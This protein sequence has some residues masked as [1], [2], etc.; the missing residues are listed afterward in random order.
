MP[1]AGAIR[2][3]IDVIEQARFVPLLIKTNELSHPGA[4]TAALLVALAACCCR[5]SSPAA[6][7]VP[8]AQVS[9]SRSIHVNQVGNLAAHQRRLVSSVGSA[10]PHI[11]SSARCPSRVSAKRA[12][13]CLSLHANANAFAR[14]YV[15]IACEINQGDRDSMAIPPPANKVK[16]AMLIIDQIDCDSPTHPKPLTILLFIR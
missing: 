7:R 12:S 13:C 15:P 4:E 9:A 5:A 11:G 3:A 10:P 16:S 1:P 2:R 6:R 8:Y 14:R